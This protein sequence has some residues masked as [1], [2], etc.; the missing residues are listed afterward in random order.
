MSKNATDTAYILFYQ[1]VQD[2]SSHVPHPLT[3]HVQKEKEDSAKGQDSD[4]Y[5]SSVVLFSF[6]SSHLDASRRQ[7]KQVA[8][9]EK[10]VSCP[11]SRPCVLIVCSGS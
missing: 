7:T 2:Q 9:K 5:S 6:S 1:A 10:G 3:T 11:I 4:L 8:Q